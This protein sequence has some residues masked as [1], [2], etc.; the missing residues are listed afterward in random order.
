LRSLSVR[1][2]FTLIAA[3]VALL[4]IS[5]ACSE[6]DSSDTAPSAPAASDACAEVSEAMTTAFPDLTLIEDE[7]R[8][9]LGD[10]EG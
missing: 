2:R 4:A 5:A 9:L 1:G 7:S 6:G 8:Y 3:A 10:V